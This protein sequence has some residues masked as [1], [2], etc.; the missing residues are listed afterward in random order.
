MDGRLHCVPFLILVVGYFT[1][2]TKVSQLNQMYRF[3][4][5]EERFFQV[6]HAD[7]QGFHINIFAMTSDPKV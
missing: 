3:Y 4:F 6:Y 7:Y 5:R 2:A 1:V